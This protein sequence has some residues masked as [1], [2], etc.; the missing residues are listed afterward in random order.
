MRDALAAA[1]VSTFKTYDFHEVW[2]ERGSKWI[3]PHIIAALAQQGVTLTR[4]PGS[5]ATIRYLEQRLA[6]YMLAASESDR[7]REP[8]RC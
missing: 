6:T 3:A 1:L 2:S 4:E 7:T 8:G 5:E